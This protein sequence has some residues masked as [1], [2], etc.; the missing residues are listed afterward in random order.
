MNQNTEKLMENLLLTV[1]SG[2][3]N[4]YKQSISEIGNYMNQLQYRIEIMEKQIENIQKNN[5]G[6]TKNISIDKRITTCRS[7]IDDPILSRIKSNI[8]P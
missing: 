1:N 7:I 3:K 2:D 8:S 5:I 6:Y 4:K